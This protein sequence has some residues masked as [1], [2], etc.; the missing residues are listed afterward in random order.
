[1][2]CMRLSVLVGVGLA[3]GVS[4]GC[5]SPSQGAIDHR[6]SLVKDSYVAARSPRALNDLALEAQNGA[7]FS[8]RDLRGKWSLVFVGY[9]SCPDVCPTT[10]AVV[11]DAMRAAASATEAR[12]SFRAVF[13]SV[14]PERDSPERLASY[15][16]YF[17]PEILA[18]TGSPE[19]IARFAEQ[20][21]AGYQRSSN[22][23]EF[24]TFEHSTSLFVLDPAARVVGTILHP[25]TAD[26][27]LRDL[28][29]AREGSAKGLEISDARVLEAP[30]VAT[31]RAGFFSA[32]NRSDQ[33]EE[34]VSA[35]SPWFDRIELHRTVSSDGHARMEKVA[36]V[37]VPPNA[38]VVLEPGG[39]HLMLIGPHDEFRMGAP[40]PVEI[41]MAD[42]GRRWIELQRPAAR[43]QSGAPTP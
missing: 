18:T 15:V 30:E 40:V 28:A 11:A 31:V 5:Q 25:S 12:T 32:H 10:L 22:D 4:L 39:Y 42:G 16:Q 38:D 37:V 13:L 7:L 21:G 34:I 8:E 2:C 26:Q 1:M 35:T 17:H 27:L 20:L 14:D 43:S 33:S 41:G 19:A 3:L 23:G 9:S 24:V 29:R 36:G 6:L